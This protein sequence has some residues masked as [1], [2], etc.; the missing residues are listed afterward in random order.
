MIPE[1]FA[2]DV[3]AF[4]TVLAGFCIVLVLLTL[5]TD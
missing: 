2:E 3:V 1:Y 4:V 5:I